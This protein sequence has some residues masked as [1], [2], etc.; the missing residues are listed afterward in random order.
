MS[1]DAMV[2]AGGIPKPGESLYEFTQGGSKALIDVAGKP[3]VQWVMDALSDAKSVG[4]VVVV[5]LNESDG[6]NCKKELSYLPNQ[7]GMLD[8]IRGAA[9]KI[10][11]QNPQADYVLIVSA[12]IPTIN[13]EIVDWVS[14]QVKPG[15]DE[16]VYN[17][18]EHSVM[19]KRFPDSRRTFTKLKGI[20]VCGGDLNPV[21]LPLILSHTGPWEKISDA[22]KSALK[23]ASL[24]GFDTLILF[25]LRAM[26]L[27]QA[28]ARASKNLGL[29]ARA[30]LC[31]YAELGMDVDKA[32]HLQTVRADMESKRK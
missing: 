14:A 22:R 10:T 3:M 2:L 13:G 1:F 17:V 18:I 28:A 23:Q 11:E 31:P 7:G 30:V 19:E 20:E 15:E 9:R 25:L 32:Y 8:N 16:A 4:K 5:G 21:S 6:L 12:D 26:T 27:E 29:R 24:I